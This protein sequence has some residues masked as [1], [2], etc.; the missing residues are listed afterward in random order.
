MT[1]KLQER[2]VLS[3]DIPQRK[4]MLSIYSREKNTHE[5]SN[6]ASN[7]PLGCLKKLKNSKSKQLD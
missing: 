4:E 5:V 2:K 1:V 7:G 3:F 6:N